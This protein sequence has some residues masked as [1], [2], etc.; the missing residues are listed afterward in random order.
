MRRNLFDDTHEL[1]RESSAT[2][3]AKQ[4]APHHD[5]WEQAGSIDKAMSRRA[6][7]AGCL[8]IAAPA[9]YGGGGTPDF[10]TAW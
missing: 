2:L 4:I 5:A 9:D 6:G 7:A 8:G 3:I 10:P 1:F